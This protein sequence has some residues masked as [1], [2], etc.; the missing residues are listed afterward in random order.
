MVKFINSW[1]QGIILGVII[2]TIIEMILPEGNNKKFVKTVIGVYILF[3]IVHPLINAVSNKSINLNSIIDNTTKEMEKHDNN[4][5][6]IETN[7]YI[8]T[9]Y[10]NKVEEHLKQRLEEKG[11]SVLEIN[12]YLETQ[13]EQRYGEINTMVIKIVKTENERNENNN[14]NNIEKINIS[15]SNTNEI[16][17]NEENNPISE[18][19]ISNIKEYL[20]TTYSVEVEKIHINE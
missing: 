10:K 3:T 7:S 8:E 18:D 17:E 2:A 15:I 1:A 19:E 4:L 13:D 5:I 6:A 11:Y 16:K 20:N 12:L 9:T 14:V